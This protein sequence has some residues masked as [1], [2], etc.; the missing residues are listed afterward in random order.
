[1]IRQAHPFNTGRLLLIGWSNF[2]DLV[3]LFSDLPVLQYFLQIGVESVPE[4]HQVV[5]L[6][7]AL[8][9]T[10]LTGLQL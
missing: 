3:V 1:M 8:S 6:P 5:S 10:P 4:P 2:T 7:L 9:Q